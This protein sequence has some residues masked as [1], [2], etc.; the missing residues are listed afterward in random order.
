MQHRLQVFFIS[1]DDFVAWQ[2]KA[3]ALSGQC[4]NNQICISQSRAAQGAFPKTD[5]TKKALS[6][7]AIFQQKALQ[8]ILAPTKE[9]NKKGLSHL[10]V[11]EEKLNRG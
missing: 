10:V 3:K 9:S 5:L 8:N 7:N 6:C 11:R 4:R 1:E 2:S